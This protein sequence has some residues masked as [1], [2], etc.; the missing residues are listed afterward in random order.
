MRKATRLAL[1]FLLL[2]FLLIL[3]IFYLLLQREADR[4]GTGE[5]EGLGTPRRRGRSRAGVTSAHP[6]GALRPGFVRRA[7][8]AG[9]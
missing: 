9:A 6:E 4:A 1:H 8:T 2:L 3:V 5:R 7:G